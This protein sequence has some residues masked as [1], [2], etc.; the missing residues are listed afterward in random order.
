[1]LHVQAMSSYSELTSLFIC[2]LYT[3]EMELVFNLVELIILKTKATQTLLNLM[4]VH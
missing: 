1:M 2:N 4:L 3:L